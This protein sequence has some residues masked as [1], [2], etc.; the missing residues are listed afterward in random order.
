MA[1]RTAVIVDLLVA[2]LFIFTPEIQM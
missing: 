2:I 1:A